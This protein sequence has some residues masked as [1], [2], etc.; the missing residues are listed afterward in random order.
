MY[1]LKKILPKSCLKNIY[2]ALIHS[3]LNYGVLLWGYES[4]RI[5]KLQK[6]ALR[7]LSKTHYLAHTDPLFKKEKI[8]KVA[9]IFKIQSYKLYYKFVKNRLPIKLMRLFKFEENNQMRLKFY[10]CT[11][12]SARNRIRYSL[13][14]LVNNS[15]NLIIEKAFTHSFLGYKNYIKK[16]MIDSYDDSPCTVQDCFSCRRNFLSHTQ[17]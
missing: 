3:H 2:Q 17:P 15:S 4:H 14:Q 13:P 7:L 16:K 10:Q 12:K 11:Q 8:L 1:Y 6:R 5:F 9:D